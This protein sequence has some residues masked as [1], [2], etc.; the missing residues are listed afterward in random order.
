MVIFNTVINTL[1][2]TIKTRTDL[3]YTLHKSSH[4]TNILQ[5]A[6]DTCLVA[7]YPAACQYLLNMTEQWL[8]W[9]GMEAKIPKCYSVSVQG[10]TGHTIDPKLRLRNQLLPFIGSNPVR[11]LGMY[12]SIPQDPSQGRMDVAQKLERMLK[13]VD[14]CPVTRHQKLRIYKL[15]VCPRLNW[16]LTIHQFPLTWIERQ[17]QPLATRSLKK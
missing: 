6:D 10:S 5:Y 13:C 8:D 15:G 4:T 1:I 16:S 2:D 9:A 11:F 7:N 3:G 12:I 17:L 14:Q